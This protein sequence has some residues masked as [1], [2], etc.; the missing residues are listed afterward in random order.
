MCSSDL[1][2]RIRVVSGR[3]RPGGVGRGGARAPERRR[4]GDAERDAAP[5][6]GIAPGCNAASGPAATGCNVVPDLSAI[7]SLN[8]AS[9]AVGRQTTARAGERTLPLVVTGDDRPQTVGPAA[10][11]PGRIGA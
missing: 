3:Y 11:R 6:I 4:P 7:P 5:G 9:S 10:P 2:A 1:S 8:A